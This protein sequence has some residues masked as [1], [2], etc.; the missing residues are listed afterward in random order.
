MSVR[1]RLVVKPAW[2]FLLAALLAFGVYSTRVCRTLA[3]LGDSGELTA[4]AVVWGVPHPPGYPLYTSLGHLAT[5]VPWG[6][7]ALRMNLT[8]AV[9]HALAVGFVAVLAQRLA[10]S[11]I[12][13]LAAGLALI[14]SKSF[15][16]G[17]LYAE[18]FPLNDLFFAALLW[19]AAAFA[20]APR[21]ARAKWLFALAFVLSLAAAH[22]LMIALGL[23]ALLILAL[24]KALGVLR[25]ERR[26]AGPLILT[27]VGP[28]LVSYASILWLAHRSPAVSFGDVHDLRSLVALVLRSDY[29]GPLS[30]TLHPTTEPF[31]DRVGAFV[32]LLLQS[33]GPIGLAGAALGAIGLVRTDR[34][35]CAALGTAVVC[36]GPLF[37]ALNRVSVDGEAQLAFFERFT[38]M[39]HVPVAVLL[40]VGT[41]LAIEWIPAA[42]PARRFV[43]LA[44]AAVP[45]L[46][47]VPGLDA[48]DLSR[49]KSGEV[50][51]QD[52][53]AGVPEGALVM[54]AGDE[55]TSAALYLCATEAACRRFHI[56][57]PGQL[58][59]PWKRAQFARR[60]PEIWLPDGPITLARSHE[61][62]AHE[63]ARRPVFVG[64]T[65]VIRDRALARDF[66]I[67][68]DRLLARVYPD[69]ASAEAD[70]Q[71]VIGHIRAMAEGR[72]CAGCQLDPR[73]VLRPSQHVDVLALYSALLENASVIALRNGAPDA[74]HA[75]GLRYWALDR[76]IGPVMV[77]HAG[78]AE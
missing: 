25:A 46:A 1:V 5:L 22:Q 69:R 66:S 61:I 78:A 14:L 7:V 26:R 50:V 68:P 67:V 29:G 51:A 64:P 60:H 6:N 9:Y 18:V 73:D 4:A 28:C 32:L 13:A 49:D 74:G 71:S 15:L 44:L 10:G 41:K 56:L 36:S 63:L 12:A 39:A 57:P 2:V 23:P 54:L 33:F 16:T 30:A 27:L 37:L 65:V 59:I 43:E 45:G 53:L 72:E 55:L 17:S 48:V 47:L 40:G 31:A 58:F 77:K 70:R 34:R 42:L 76:A 35:A 24:P 11:V 62:V 38:T 19:V 8:S 75:L 3:L 20:E 52:L 21:A